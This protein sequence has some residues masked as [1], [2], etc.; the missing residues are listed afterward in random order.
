MKQ[1]GLRILICCLG[2]GFVPGVN[3]ETVTIAYLQDGLSEL[4]KTEKQVAF[5]LWAEELTGK[6]KFE[7]VILPVTTMSRMSALIKAK[8]VNFAILNT[9]HFLNHRDELQE[10][11]DRTIWAV[12]RTASLYE[13][14]IVVTGKEK[15]IEKI[16]QLAGKRFSIAKDRLLM[17]FYLDYLILKAGYPVSAGFFKK[18]KETYT[19]SQA[20]L[21]VFFGKSDACIVPKHVFDMAVE[22]NPSI[23]ERLK[24]IHRS[25]ANFIPVLIIGSVFNSD[26]VN[27]VLSDS[28]NKIH[29]SPR[30]E[31]I[32]DLLKIHSAVVIGPE[33]LAMMS[34][35]YSDYRRL[36]GSGR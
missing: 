11:F 18:V 1:L 17:N 5:K 25:G 27:S 7:V 22:L 13:E 31:Q 10:Y 19:A 29:D 15:N 14:Y 3:A 24:I 33:Q 32:I 16:A 34:S 23:M 12:Q 2:L 9:V 30:G 6:G 4:Q 20:V 28:I 26:F 21:D 35:I 36:S 8:A